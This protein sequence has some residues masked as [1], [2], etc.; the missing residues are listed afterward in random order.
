MTVATGTLPT[1][2]IIGAMKSGSTTLY[3]H[4][5][6]HPDIFLPAYKEPEFFVAEKT[7]S[8]GLSWYSSLFAEAGDS[9]AVG[10]ASTSYTKF[11]EFDG[12]P[13]RIASV[14]PQAQLVYVLREPLARMR[15]MYQHQVLTGRE[16]RPIDL[17]LLEDDRYIGPS[18][19]AENIRR[20]LD[21]FPREQ[22][23]LM[24]TDDLQ[25]DPVE[26]VRG[27]TTFLG[28]SDEPDF[29]PESRVDL[30]TSDRR[31]DRRLKSRVRGLA[32]VEVAFR[33]AP[34]PVQDA[35]R[36]LTTRPTEPTTPTLPSPATERALL[37][38]LQPDLLEL[39]C[40]L[41]DNFAAWDLLEP[42]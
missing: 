18:L 1:F 4:L 37:D 14:L 20:Y 27:V 25:A 39:H 19:Y 35:L 22:L 29:V 21:H 24:L 11:T 10:E 30:R 34:G 5:R 15:S 26:A 8:R 36:R 13:A 6:Q 17:A 40:L 31:A 12:V 9:I 3:N 2:L 28:L 23:H 16:R 32:P 38:R 7:W 33:R 41:G 42:Q